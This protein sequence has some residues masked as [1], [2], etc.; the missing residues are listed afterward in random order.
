MKRKSVVSVSFSDCAVSLLR[1]TQ[2]KSKIKKSGSNV[3]SNIKLLK[4]VSH[5]ST[6][7][8]S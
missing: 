7:S 5:A 2:Q 6:V 4:S 1:H 8:Q 3:F